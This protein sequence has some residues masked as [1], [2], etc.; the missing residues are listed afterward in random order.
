MKKMNSKIF[1]H[2]LKNH[3]IFKNKNVF[4]KE[5]LNLYHIIIFI[6]SSIIIQTNSIIDKNDLNETIY[7]YITL[8]IGKGENSVYSSEYSKAPKFVY[9]NKIKQETIET[10]YLFN[11]SENSVI[12]IWEKPILDCEKLFTSC[13]KITEINLTHF[14][15]SQVNT[16][17]AMFK[18]CFNLK[19]VDVSNLDTSNVT[20][21]GNMF[22]S[23][24][25]LISLDV[26]NFK[27]SSLKRM[28]GM[29]YGCSSLKS[30]DLS[31]FDTSKTTLID[32]LFVG[33]S[34]LTFINLSNF[35]TSKVKR[36]N[37]MFNNCTSLISIDFQNLDLSSCYNANNI[38]K[39]CYNLEYVNIKNFKPESN[40]GY[41]YFFKDCPI[42]IAICLNDE[43]LI[44]IIKSNECNTFSC[45]VNWY[46]LKK[47]NL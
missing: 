8:K 11:E 36:M 44:N 20:E 13:D 46:N 2:R 4:I 22:I 30:I 27:T 38:F 28:G 23:C 41:N 39:N 16:M 9:I 40:A 18:N 25:S 19:Y 21:M 7:S 29:F 45:S 15:T 17:L 10:N 6:I 14:D 24:G 42:N 32:S 31:N 33:C 3:K 1:L 47:K 12:L 34:N 37:D 26:S 43:T 35:H 5:K